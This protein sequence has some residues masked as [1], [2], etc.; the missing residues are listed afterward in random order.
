MNE[1]NPSQVFDSG[2]DKPTYLPPS[3]GTNPIV[4]KQYLTGWLFR[5]P[6]G[7]EKYRK[8]INKSLP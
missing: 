6:V 3:S 1:K 4:N 5:N 8:E 7:I 2:S